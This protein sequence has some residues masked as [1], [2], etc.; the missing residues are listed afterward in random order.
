MNAWDNFFFLF[1]Y[2]FIH[3]LSVADSPQSIVCPAFIVMPNWKQDNQM[4]QGLSQ[5]SLLL[6]CSLYFYPNLWV[7]IY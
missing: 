4:L 2:L 5:N 3:G 1:T 6:P 7:T